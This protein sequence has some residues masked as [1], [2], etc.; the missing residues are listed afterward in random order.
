MFTEDDYNIL[1]DL[2]FVDGFPGFTPDV[3]ESPN[4]DGNL[5]SEKLYSHVSWKYLN[6]LPF[7]TERSTLTE[8][9]QKAHVLAEAA[10]WELNLPVKWH[11]HFASGT[12]RI[13]KYPPGA[14]THPHTDFDLFTINMYRNETEHFVY[15]NDDAPIFNNPHLK[16]TFQTGELLEILGYGKATVHEVLPSQ[17]VQKSIVYF[18]IPNPELTLPCD[19]TVKDWLDERLARSRYYEPDQFTL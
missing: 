8:Y 5:D 16:N 12:L 17:D 4:G 18:A 7:G 19:M 9:L 1:H 13:L 14:V 15:P 6:Q 2:T 11:P 3:I 10:A